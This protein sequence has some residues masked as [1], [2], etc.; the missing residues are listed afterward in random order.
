MTLKCLKKESCNTETKDMT[1]YYYKGVGQAC[2]D[3]IRKIKPWNQFQLHRD[4][5][6]K[7]SFISAFQNK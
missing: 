6:K 5:K 1:E 2:K 3:W 7:K 4:L